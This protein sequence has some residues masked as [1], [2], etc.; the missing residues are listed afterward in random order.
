MNYSETTS[1]FCA[2]LAGITALIVIIVQVRAKILKRGG[3]LFSEDTEDTAAA[4]TSPAA[5]PAAAP[6]IVPAAVPVGV[7]AGLPVMGP[8][9][10]A[11]AVVPQPEPDQAE[12]GEPVTSLE[13]VTLLKGLP[14]VEAERAKEQFVGSEV[15]WTLYY[16]SMMLK[17]S[18]QVEVSLLNANNDYPGV[19]F[20]VDLNQYPELRNIRWQTPVTVRGTISSVYSMYIILTDVSLT[21]P[22][23]A[24]A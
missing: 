10:V 17:G 7:Q 22:S 8:Q 9:P 4:E 11:P 14:P 15:E 2:A 19:S 20:M 3:G 18:N 12:D 5:A 13:I 23:T 6:T 1:I 24:S 16:S 21:F